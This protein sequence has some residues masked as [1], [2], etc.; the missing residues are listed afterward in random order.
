MDVTNTPHIPT[1]IAAVSTQD[2]VSITV[3]RKAQDLQAT[4]AAAMIEALPPVGSANLPAHL[5]QNIDT[6]A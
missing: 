5:G 1:S 3:L 4:N 6:T 2:V